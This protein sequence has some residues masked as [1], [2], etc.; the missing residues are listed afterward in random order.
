MKYTQLGKTDLIVSRICFGCWQLSPKFW[1]QISIDDWNLAL[2][3]AIDCGINFI[4]TAQAYGDGFAEKVLGDFLEKNKCRKNLIIATKFFWNIENPEN[5]YPDT[6]YNYIISECEASLKRLKTDY[7]DLYQI[8][9][10]DSLTKPDEVA[11]A[12]LKLKKDGK[13]RWIGV[14]NLNVH[15][16]SMYMRYFEINCLQPLYNILD[17]QAEQELFPFCLEKRIGVITYSTLA[18]GLLAGKYTGDE[19]FSDSRANHP[20]F[21]GENFKKI[22]TAINTYMKPVAEQLSITVPELAIRWVLT[23]P[24]VTSAIVGIKKPEHIETIIKAAD[25]VLDR[26]LWYKLA[27]DIKNATQ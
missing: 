12:L 11:S 21:T 5:R 1:G 18:R 14:S 4:D 8:H 24:A 27:D 3:K 22:I 23:H 13:I 19:K 6:D 16:M 9:A 15:Q 10:W 20:R 25:D 17:R 2:L 26:K 7:I